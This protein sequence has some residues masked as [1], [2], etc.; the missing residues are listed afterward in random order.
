MRVE[1]IIKKHG[2]SNQSLKSYEVK[3]DTVVTPNRTYLVG[4]C[5]NNITS[6]DQPQKYDYFEY[7]N[8][9][10]IIN[11]T[12]SDQGDIFEI[13]IL[14]YSNGDEL[15]NHVISS[16]CINNGSHILECTTY[17]AIETPILYILNMNDLQTVPD[18]SG[19]TVIE[20]I[21]H[22]MESLDDRGLQNVDF[23]TRFQF[24]KPKVNG[25]LMDYQEF[26][27]Y[28]DCSF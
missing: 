2:E 4:I 20:C 3:I 13:Q 11:G 8:I 15:V 9:I 25:K 26:A 18:Y 6:E 24:Y 27:T 1:G 17:G 10:S 16:N 23:E 5:K 12:V 7:R 21:E 22:F 28:T 19:K 14:T